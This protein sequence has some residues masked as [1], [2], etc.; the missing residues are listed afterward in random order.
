MITK[1][2]TRFSRLYYID[3]RLMVCFVN[4]VDLVKDFF[5]PLVEQISPFANDEGADLTLLDSKYFLWLNDSAFTTLYAIF[6]LILAIGE[7]V[8][9]YYILVWITQGLEATVDPN[10]PAAVVV[11][12]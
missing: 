5:R 7:A 10:P 4:I 3:V 8:F 11:K 6:C 2:G 12:S 9:L 1:A